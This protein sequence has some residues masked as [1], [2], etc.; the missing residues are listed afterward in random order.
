MS[1]IAIIH[2][3]LFGFNKERSKFGLF[4]RLVREK[5]GAH[6]DMEIASS[7]EWD[8]SVMTAEA[9]EADAF[10]D[11]RMIMRLMK[12]AGARE[13]KDLVGTR[14][15]PHNDGLEVIND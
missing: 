5:D 3:V 6:G 8:P 12:D 15:R 11:Y 14:I 1:D 9:W 13:I 4:A 10:N 2:S 7:I